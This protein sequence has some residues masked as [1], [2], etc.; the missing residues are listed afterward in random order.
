[1]EGLLREEDLGC[2]AKRQISGPV[3]EATT[4]VSGEAQA[5]QRW[6]SGAPL[7]R[8]RHTAVPAADADTGRDDRTLYQPRA[9]ETF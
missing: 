2:L 3:P 7:L 9:G 1:M 4:G 8:P 6:R 5:L